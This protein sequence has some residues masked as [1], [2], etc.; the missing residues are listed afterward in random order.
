M[1]RFHTTLLSP[2]SMV[3]RALLVLAGCLCLNSAAMADTFPSKA[4]TIVVPFP[5]G[6]PTDANARLIGKEL[7]QVLG[8]PVVIDNRAGAGGTVGSTFVA[9]APADG[10]TLLW[11]G[12]SSL[13]VAPA[14]YPN[15]NYDPVKSFQPIGMVVRGPM[16]LA[17][18]AG[19]PAKT[20]TELLA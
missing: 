12:T 17:G 3:R 13:V 10:Y 18:R 16:M 7:S 5:A 14:L 19:L 15:L 2:V 6:G 11:G 8:Q 1:P 20:M 4:I 9:R